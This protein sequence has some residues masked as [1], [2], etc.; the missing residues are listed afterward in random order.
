MNK[1]NAGI[2]NII[3][4]ANKRIK[5]ATKDINKVV[6]TVIEKIEDNRKEA[7][8]PVTEAP[9]EEAPIAE[10]PVEEAPMTEI[11]VEEVSTAEIAVEEPVP[12]EDEVPAA[13]HILKMESPVEEEVTLVEEVAEPEIDFFTIEEMQIMQS[14][15]KMGRLFD[16][17]DEAR[18][19]KLTED[20]TTWINKYAHTFEDP[21]SL[22]FEATTPLITEDM[23]IGDIEPETVS[24]EPL[25][26]EPEYAME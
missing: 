6:D 1:A 15:A 13:E 21:E 10:A 11:A 4:K 25:Y 14:L 9:V 26:L 12:I 5:D 22:L 18:M 3:E 2:Q 20:L 23:L 8:E 16:D 7:S 17:V 19:V 24:E